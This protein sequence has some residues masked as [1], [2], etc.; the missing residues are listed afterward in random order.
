MVRRVRFLA[1]IVAS[2]AMTASF[3]QAV[4]AS[5]CAPGM[6]MSASAATASEEAPEERHC[7]HAAP[8]GGEHGAGAD[9]GENAGHCPF[10]SPVAAQSCVGVASL[11]A[12]VLILSAG[13]SRGVVSSFQIDDQRDLLLQKTL[14]H[15]PRA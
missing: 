4:W 12:P 9:A 6:P 2:L 15:P 14:F 5:M 7:G 8:G 11:P 10:D 3:S 13:S 1:G